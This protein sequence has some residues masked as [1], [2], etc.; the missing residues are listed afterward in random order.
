MKIKE[1]CSV[2]TSDFLYDLMDGGYLNPEEILEDEKDVKAV[3]DA[4]KVLMNFK[5]SCGDQIEEF[6][7]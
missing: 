5:E 3:N 4:I 2:S 6:Y 1:N 7:C